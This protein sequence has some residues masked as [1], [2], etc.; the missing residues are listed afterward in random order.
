[1]RIGRNPAKD[2]NQLKNDIDHRIIIPVYIPTL[3]GYF[4]D[5]LEI[6]KI[7]LNSLRC[8]ASGKA[9]IT[10]VSN[11][12]SPDVMEEL[13]KQYQEGWIDQ[14]VFNHRNR[15]KV[16]AVISIA[17]GSFER[18]LTISDCD[19]LFKSSWLEQVETI[20][21]TFPECAYVSP[22]PAPNMIGN[23]NSA[24]ILAA[25]A[26]RELAFEKVVPDEDLDRFACSIGSPNLF[27]SQHRESQLVV[28][29]NGIKAC[30][31]C[32]H[33]ALTIRRE[34]LEGM[35]KNPSLKAIDGNSETIWLDMPPDK[36]GLWR[37]AT[38]KAYVYHLGNML[39]PWMYDE[40]KLSEK[41]NGRSKPQALDLPQLKPHWTS[42]VSWSIRNHLVK[43]LMKTGG[44]NN[45]LLGRLIN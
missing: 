7:C 41:N 39:E 11:G 4:E 38:T 23:Y 10:I 20:F 45:T 2:N 33:F 22:M 14:L 35:P 8:T 3:T 40:L 13:D 27:N 42:N 12:S 29:R 31:G 37:L 44:T 30:I 34:V 26:K 9:N 17:R 1:M 32:G 19:V 21:Y 15:G 43:L 18:L 36:L 24:G 25:L 28:K 6:L 16:D 5:S